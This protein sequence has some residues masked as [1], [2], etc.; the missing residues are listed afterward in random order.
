MEANA[1]QTQGD[2]FRAGGRALE[3]Q[4]EAYYQRAL[5]VARSHMAKS[6]ELRAG[7]ALASLWRDQGQV[8]QARALLAPLHAWFVEGK[9]TADV[10]RAAELLSEL[11]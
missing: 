1:Y 4:A 11:G 3:A 8:D 6:W 9:D 7:I 2:I 10:K 5:E